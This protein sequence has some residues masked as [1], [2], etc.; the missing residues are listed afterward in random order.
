M[1]QVYVEPLS[2]RFVRLGSYKVFPPVEEKYVTVHMTLDSIKF[3]AQSV[4]GYFPF[5]EITIK[6]DS[7]NEMM[8]C[9]GEKPAL[10]ILPNNAFAEEVRFAL[11]ID[12]HCPYAFDPSLKDFRSMF[13]I[14]II[15]FL[16]EEQ[17]HF[18]RN[19]YLGMK[20]CTEI[21]KDGCRKLMRKT[22]PVI[23]THMARILLSNDDP[24]IVLE[25]GTKEGVSSLVS[26][27]EVVS[28][29]SKSRAGVLLLSN[30]D[31]MCLTNG[32]WL[33]DG[34]VN[35]YL[36]Y[37]YSEYLSENDRE[38]THI[39]S[40]F[41]FNN[42]SRVTEKDVR[43]DIPPPPL[44]KRFNL[45]KSWTRR[46]DLFSKD[47][48]V[49]PVNNCGH[50]YLVIVCFPGNMTDFPNTLKKS[51][52]NN[53]NMVNELGCSQVS[54]SM[55]ES[56]ASDCNSNGSQRQGMPCICVFD[57]MFD[58]KRSSYAAK[59]VKEYLEVEYVI[60]KGVYLSFKPIRV[61]AMNCPQQTNASDCGVYLL[62]NFETFFKNPFKIE[63]IVC[64]I[65]DTGSVHHA[66]SLRGR[67]F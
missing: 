17:I 59:L 39:F 61:F 56:S 14:F 31:L 66:F 18:I 41:F 28:Y 5:H 12:L 37:I 32:E 45:V 42:I 35:F 43:V 25:E 46:V 19:H 33:N 10:F 15:S 29:R 44:A 1:D 64:Q 11:D 27:R 47:Y 26:E 8:F 54:A 36:E 49:I 16:T 22:A 51:D 62:K 53:E 9:L 48:I 40:F 67:I 65:Y 24:T 30:R 2:C 52:M 20:T 6:C 7:S 58:V 4:K 63:A 55:D 21:S 50:W 3:K 57:S 34:I 38:R 23:S 13:V 60:R